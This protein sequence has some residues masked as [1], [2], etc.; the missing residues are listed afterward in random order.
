MARKQTPMTETQ[1]TVMQRIKDLRDKQIRET[2]PA[3]DEMAKY[4]GRPCTPSGWLS[5]VDLRYV[6]KLPIRTINALVANGHL[7]QQRCHLGGYE[8]KPAGYPDPSPS[9]P[10]PETIL[11]PDVDPI[12]VGRKIGAA[13]ARDAIADGR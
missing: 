6:H 11:A 12:D 7:E 10:P 13:M 5:L 4:D 1:K 8:V 9:L 3:C 2:R